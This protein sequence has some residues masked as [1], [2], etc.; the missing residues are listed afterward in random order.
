MV[1]I[2]VQS[3]QC[4]TWFGTKIFGTGSNTLLPISKVNILNDFSQPQHAPTSWQAK[5]CFEVSH[6]DN[7]LQGKSLIFLETFGCLFFMILRT[8]FGAPKITSKFI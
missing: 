1:G 5:C 3:L 7:S 4:S 8:S 2:C 6:P